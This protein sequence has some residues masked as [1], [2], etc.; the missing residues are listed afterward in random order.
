MARDH[1]TYDPKFW[2]ME[3]AAFHHRWSTEERAKEQARALQRLQRRARRIAR[4]WALK[5]GLTLE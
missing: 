1:D 5:K 3:A 4:T 2:T